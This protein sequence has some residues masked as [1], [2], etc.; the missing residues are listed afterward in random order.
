[1]PAA[2]ARGQPLKQVHQQESE[3][4][5]NDG[6]D[7]GVPMAGIDGERMKAFRAR[8]SN[9]DNSA[10]NNATAQDP[11]VDDFGVGNS[12]ANNQ[13]LNE[14]WLGGADGFCKSCHARHPFP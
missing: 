9:I 11:S 8:F 13:R 7:F 4:E 2:A 1:M 6:D 5:T 14:V 3:T 12:G 10:A